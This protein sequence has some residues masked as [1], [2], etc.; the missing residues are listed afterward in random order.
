MTTT[1]LKDQIKKLV[2][3]QIMDVDVYRMKMDLRDKPAEIEQ[4]KAEFESKKAKL[5]QLEDQLK[6][7]L[8]KQKEHEGDLKSKEEAIIKADGQ[9]SLL[10]T[11]KEYSAKLSE[12]EHI[13]A[14]K[15]II[16]EKILLSYDQSDQISA[17][18]EKE[19]VRVSEFEKEFSVKRKTLEDEIKITEERVGVLESHR[20]TALTDIDMN[21]LN[22]YERILRHK[23][24]LA[25]VAVTD[26]VCGGCY[27]NVNPQMHNA[28]KL[29]DSLVECEICSRILYLE[30]D[31]W[32]AR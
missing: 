20:K 12:I 13:K 1:T 25:I 18:L 14:D 8:V 17:E 31:L 7:I 22:R 16:E 9:L 3:L 5:K 27:M 2:E 30:E 32:K 29:H 21:H 24:G 23:E 6:S 15:S 4:L 28:I 26:N 11:N 10:K 19:K